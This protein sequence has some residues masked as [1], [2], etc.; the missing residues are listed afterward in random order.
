MSSDATTDTFRFD[1]LKAVYI[2]CTL[3]KSPEVSNT[4]GLMDTSIRLMRDHGVQ[5]DNVR[6]V[7]HDIALGVYPD[8]REHGWKTDAW[9]DEVWPLIDAADI[10][11]VGGPIWLGDNSSV[12]RMLIERLYAM[13]GEFND[14]G[15]YVYYGKVGGAVITGNEDG[16]KHSAMSILYSLQHI[17]FVIPPAADAGW[18]GAIGPGPSYLD[19]GSGGPEN[20][21]TNRNTTFM[22]WN[23][24]HL[25]SILKSAGGIP[26]YGNSRRE[27]NDGERFG[28]NANPEYR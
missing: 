25:A 10:L 5:V 21:F 17:G 2:N 11:V 19:E 18:I 14:K 27:W 4:Q 8:M 6:L 7:D 13:S 24:M 20:D 3:K 12:T 23:L 15:Q 9:L 28:F 22:T 16:V 1:N 26:A